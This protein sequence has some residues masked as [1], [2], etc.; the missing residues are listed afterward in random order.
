MILF[1]PTQFLAMR[2]IGKHGLHIASHRLLYQ[3]MGLIEYTIG[4]LE[5]G[6]LR[7]RIINKARLYL[8][9]HRKMQGVFLPFQ[10]SAFHLNIPETII[11]K[12]RMPSFHSFPF[13]DI[14]II[15]LSAGLTLIASSFVRQGFGYKQSYFLPF[16]STDGN[17]GETGPG[18][19]PIS[20]TKADGSTVRLVDLQAAVICSAVSL[21][22]SRIS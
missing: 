19:C 4:T 22:T 10:H 17:F 14:F 2:T 11:R 15:M 12:T 16:L 8:L 3:P 21:V 7:S 5:C 9:N 1:Q 13:Q 6:Y 20:S 18:S